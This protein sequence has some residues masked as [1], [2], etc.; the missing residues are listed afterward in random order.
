ME[1]IKIEF[2]KSGFNHKLIERRGDW[3]VY[4]RWTDG[5]KPHYELIQIQKNEQYELGGNIIPAKESF[6]GPEKWGRLGFTITDK[7]E[8]LSR[9][10]RIEEFLKKKSEEEEEVEEVVV[11]TEVSPQP[12]KR[13]RGRPKSK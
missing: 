12:V 3:A 11:N 7:N 4:E 5:G 13:G 6:P 1:P 2:K 9:L 10:A 8:A